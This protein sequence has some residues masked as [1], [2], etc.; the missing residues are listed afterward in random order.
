MVYYTQLIFIKHGQEEAFQRFEK[1][2]LPLLEKYNG[3]LLLRWRRT[4]EGVI[5]GPDPYE[6]HLVSFGCVEDFRHYVNDE[7]REAYTH[8]RE[9]SVERMVVIEGAEVGLSPEGE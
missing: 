3:R 8:L 9:Q 2:V 5:E 6:I 1:H 4:H 7:T